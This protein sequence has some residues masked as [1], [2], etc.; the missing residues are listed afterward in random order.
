MFTRLKDAISTLE[1]A[2]LDE[3]FYLHLHYQSGGAFRLTKVFNTCLS[4]QFLLYPLTYVL[5]VNRVCDTAVSRSNQGMRFK[6]RNDLRALR[7]LRALT[8]GMGSSLLAYLIL[9]TKTEHFVEEDGLYY[10]EKKDGISVE[11]ITEDG[12]EESF[13]FE[14][15][16]K[17]SYS[18][19]R[20]LSNPVEIALNKIRNVEYRQRKRLLSV[21]FDTVEKDRLHA[22]YKGLLPSVLSDMIANITLKS[23]IAT[24]H[25][26]PLAWLLASMVCHPL[27]LLSIRVQCNTFGRHPSA[28]KNFWTAGR[29][30]IKTR[31]FLG[32]YQGFS[33][34]TLIVFTKM[35]PEIIKHEEALE[36]IEKGE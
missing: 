13:Q 27:M 35:L 5:Y 15:S 34:G 16:A 28:N 29:H 19:R 30:I 24:G 1:D 20:I 36:K 8:L 7:S 25:D 17:S 3:D 31:G 22:L 12:D 32:L 33:I 18:T 9:Y 14:T 23:F 6:L 11:L 10:Q 4:Y 2:E 26:W 21:I